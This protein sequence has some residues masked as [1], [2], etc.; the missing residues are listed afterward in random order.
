MPSWHR[1]ASSAAHFRSSRSALSALGKSHR[2]VLLDLFH[3][4]AFVAPPRGYTA[5]LHDLED[6]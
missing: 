5:S 6:S 4:D 3:S 1:V 2:D